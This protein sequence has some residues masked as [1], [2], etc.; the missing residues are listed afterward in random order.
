MPLTFHH[1]IA[2]FA[3]SGFDI[4]L[5]GFGRMSVYHGV[6]ECPLC[7]DDDFTVTSG[8]SAM[9]YH[10]LIWGFP[11][12]WGTPMDGLYMFI[13]W[14]YWDSSSFAHHEDVKIF[15]DQL[16]RD[17][18]SAVRYCTLSE[19]AKAY[20]VLTRLTCLLDH[21][22]SVG[23]EGCFELVLSHRVTCLTL[24]RSLLGFFHEMRLP[25]VTT[26]IFNVKLV[27]ILDD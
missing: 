26:S 1:G 7:G 10:V 19:M 5:C 22:R 6:N 3:E 23:I 12:S 27:G 17:L 11:E 9:L 25:Q 18:V 2:M 8:E 15:T 14:D 13:M 16:C 24:K 4:Q 20:E 21:G